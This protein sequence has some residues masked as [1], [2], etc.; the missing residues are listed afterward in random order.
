MNMKY[1]MIALTLSV[2]P[3]GAFAQE[4]IDP[5]TDAAVARANE[6]PKPVSDGTSVSVPPHA[7]YVFKD[8]SGQPCRPIDKDD[9]KLVKK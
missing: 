5:A 6:R 9:C 1:F 7:E 3:V 8:A 2:L 4:S